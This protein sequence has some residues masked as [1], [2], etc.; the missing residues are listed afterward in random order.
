MRTPHSE[1]KSLAEEMTG[2]YTDSGEIYNSH[3]VVVLLLTNTPIEKCHDII[4]G[5]LDVGTT[6]KD[7]TK[8]NSD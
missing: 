6:L 7:R 2:V 8:F 4:R 3:D 1:S 5:C